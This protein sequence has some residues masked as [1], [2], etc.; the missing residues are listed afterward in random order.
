M[1][2]GDVSLRD[3]VPI[4]K[5]KDGTPQNPGAGGWPTLRYYNKDTGVGGAIVEQNTN[6]KICD[7]FK[8]GARMI[9]AVGECMR[10]CDPG[11]G[12]GC[13]EFEASFLDEW[14]ERDGID[15]ELDKLNELMSEEGQ[16]R[17]KRQAKLLSKLQAVGSVKE[18]L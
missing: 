4:K 13:D 16:K 5:A 12:D 9:E 18:E 15:A 10:S 2:F 3:G 11:T 1:V 14:R 17:M 8:V 7:E 6:L